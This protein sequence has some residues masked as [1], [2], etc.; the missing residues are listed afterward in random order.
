M[1]QTRQAPFPFHTYRAVLQLSHALG[2]KKLSLTFSA[3]WRTILSLHPSS[4]CTGMLG[5]QFPNVGAAPWC[6]GDV[7]GC[8]KI[9][10]QLLL[11]PMSSGTRAQASGFADTKQGQA[12]CCSCWNDCSF[13][14]GGKLLQLGFK[15][16]AGPYA[17]GRGE[18]LASRGFLWTGWPPLAGARIWSHFCHMSQRHCWTTAVVICRQWFTTVSHVPY[19][20]GTTHADCQES[21]CQEVFS[22]KNIA[23]TQNFTSEARRNCFPN[24]LG[25]WLNF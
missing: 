25:L 12:I 2:E 19:T 23:Q 7:S 14:G 18:C 20:Y 11:D 8:S 4:P 15:S 9:C 5:Q 10:S 24:F 13:G 1:I 22:T 21:D 16:E 3:S 17:V 6:R